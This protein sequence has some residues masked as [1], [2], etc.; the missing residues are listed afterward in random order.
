MSYYNRYAA[1]KDTHPIYRQYSWYWRMWQ[2]FYEGGADFYSPDIP[3]SYLYP[4]LQVGE[5]GTDQFLRYDERQLKSFLWPDNREE[6]GDYDQRVI[7]STRVNFCRP[8]IDLYTAHVFS[9]PIVRESGTASIVDAIWSD[10]NLRQSTIDEWM[11]EGIAGAQVYGHMFAVVDLSH[12]DAEVQ[13][14]ADQILVNVRPYATWFTPLQV[15]DWAVDGFGNFLW[16]T[17]IE[18][19]PASIKRRPGQITSS[20]RRYRTWFPDHW[21][22]TGDMDSAHPRAEGRDSMVCPVCGADGVIDAGPNALGRVPIEVLYRKRAA[23]V[24]DPLGVS[25]LTEIAPADREIFNLISRRQDLLFQ[26]GIPILAV[27][28]PGFQLKRIELTVHRALPYNPNQGG[29]PPTY[30]APPTDI[31]RVLDEQIVAWTN[32]IRAMSGLTRGVADQSIAARSG[33]ALLIE[34]ADK[35][36]M[37]GAL[38]H[39]AEDFEM[40]LA[41]MVADYAGQSV[42]DSTVV[43]YPDRYDTSTIADNIDEANKLLALSPIPEVRAEVIKVLESRALSHLPPESLRDLLDRQTEAIVGEQK[44]TVSELLTPSDL[45]NVVTVNEARAN[46]GF[47]PLTLADGAPDPDGLLS[48]SAYRAKKEAEAQAGAGAVAAVDAN[49]A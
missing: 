40:R 27:P 10:V 1:E 19:D 44:S 17:I 33:E 7:R 46:V 14:L 41:R 43:K 32:M 31:V 37:L 2:L 12:H 36:A 8:I 47:L 6:P 25:A 49:G 23:G 18:N 28:D 42:D 21:E 5:G 9:R 29:G 24:V 13:T 3:I 20:A 15:V 35:A 26:Q 45:A 38:A 48:V 16:V 39:E 22:I 34:T 4:S 11:A 30:V